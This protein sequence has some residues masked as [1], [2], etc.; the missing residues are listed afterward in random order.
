MLKRMCLV[1]I[2]CVF[3]VAA[4]AQGVAAEIQQYNNITVTLS[5]NAHKCEFKDR[6]VFLAALEE[7][8]A[9]IGLPR[10]DSSVLTANL[11][12]SGNTFGLLK[13]ECTYHVSLSFLAVL[14]KDNLT[15]I[16]PQAMAAIGRLEQLPIV[17]YRRGFFGVEV[18]RQPN[19]GGPA[20]GPRD[21]VLQ[22]I[23]RLVDRFAKDRKG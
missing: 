2:A 1:L 17:L 22:A 13:A 14:S 5:E 15:N 19:A 16:P 4:H 18:M 6:K 3:P 20:I 7:N 10:R 21:A 9:R 8:F 23:T 12:I 11:A